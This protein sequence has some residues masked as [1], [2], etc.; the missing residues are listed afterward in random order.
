MT[1]IRWS[2]LFAALTLL[3]LGI[4]E[5]KLAVNTVGGQIV[6]QQLMVD[7]AA[8]SADLPTVS[9]AFLSLVTP[10]LMVGGVFVVL[11]IALRDSPIA[12]A[13]RVAAVTLGPIATAWA[14]KR[15]LKRPDLDGVVMHNSFPSGTLTTIA[16]LVCAIVFVTP[17]RW[18]VIVAING[19]LISIGTAVSV[20]VLKWHRPSDVIGA[21]L[22]VGCY[23]LAVSA[24][25]LHA[26]VPP[27][28][29]LADP[30]NERI[31]RECDTPAPRAGKFLRRQ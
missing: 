31:F 25:P 29:V 7:A 2:R 4:L 28:R 20:V 8:F 18:R 27:Q 26:K 9:A 10:I 6:D 22:L 15:S 24:F 17:P 5:F 21:L 1:R 3:A 30:E 23:T 19:A 12:L 14:L 13:L 16:A 11:I